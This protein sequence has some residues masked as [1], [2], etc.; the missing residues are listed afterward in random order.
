M[1][2][3][4]CAYSSREAR[5]DHPPP[6]LPSARRKRTAQ[7][8]YARLRRC[9]FLIGRLRGL[10]KRTERDE[11]YHVWVHREADGLCP[12]AF[13][14]HVAA[15]LRQF[16][17]EARAEHEADLKHAAVCVFLLSNNFFGCA[18]TLGPPAR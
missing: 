18:R 10:Q 12:F 6:P 4:A 16:G 17:V 13:G 1:R 8:L 9:A 5:S 7:E 11:P 3:R 14:E 2:R 15:T